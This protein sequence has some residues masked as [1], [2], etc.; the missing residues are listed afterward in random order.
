MSDKPHNLHL[1][2]VV[3]TVPTK[4]SVKDNDHAREL[5]REALR[6]VGKRHEELDDWFLRTADGR[7]IKPN[8]KLRDAGIVDGMTLYLTKD[9]GGGG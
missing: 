9:A 4:V 8:E 5:M 6:E 7:E 2:V 3:A 1:T